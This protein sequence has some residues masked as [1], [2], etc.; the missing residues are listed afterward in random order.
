MADGANYRGGL[1][2]RDF[3]NF[4][5]MFDYLLKMCIPNIFVYY[6]IV[7]KAIFLILIREK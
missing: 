6:K 4:A 1:T 5:Y 7:S 3:F 2:N